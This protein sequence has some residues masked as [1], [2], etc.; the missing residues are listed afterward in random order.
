MDTLTVKAYYDFKLEDG[1]QE[2]LVDVFIKGFTNN[3]NDYAKSVVTLVDAM[4]KTGPNTVQHLQMEQQLIY[5]GFPLF[6]NMVV[7]KLLAKQYDGFT[8]YSG[9][10]LD[11]EL[12][13]SKIRSDGLIVLMKS[14][15]NSRYLCA[16]KN[17]LDEDT[18]NNS[19]FVWDKQID[20]EFSSLNKSKMIE[21]LFP[22]SAA[23]LVQKSIEWSLSGIGSCP[24]A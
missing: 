4:I 17:S 2:K 5:A 19:F 8:I 20:Q 24:V 15:K 16:F 12:Q 23:T 21:V 6:Y 11:A 14:T 13:A 1:K 22:Y 10:L 3:L 9:R 18:D 7:T